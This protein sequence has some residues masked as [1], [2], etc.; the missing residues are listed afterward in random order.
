MGYG[1]E[2]S[3]RV[4]SMNTFRYGAVQYQSMCHDVHNNF[5][6]DFD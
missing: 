5:H 3:Y 2:Y 1:L 6:F 4:L